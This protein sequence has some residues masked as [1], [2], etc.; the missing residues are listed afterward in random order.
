MN[1]RYIVE[2]SDDERVQ[3]DA[4]IAAPK[5]GPQMRTRAQL[6]LACGRGVPDAT[7]AEALSCGTSTIYRTKKRFVEEGLEAALH[8]LPREG[9]KRK[10][11][12]LEEAK[13]VALACS[14]PPVGR[15]RWTLEL[16]ADEI[17]RLTD[18]E[19]ISKETIRRRLGEN[20]LKPWRRKMW[21]IAELDAEYV[22]RMEDV[23]D[24]YAETPDQKRPVVSFDETPIQLIG[25]TRTPVPAKPGQPARIDYEYRRNGTAN[26]FI[27]VDAHRSWRHVKVT[28]Q[29]TNL[30]FA[31]CMRD[32][33]DIHYPN[34][35]RIRVVLDN[36]STHKA[37]NLYEAFAPE[38]ARR[39]LRR[40]E[41]H[42]T[43][44]HASWLNMVEIEISVLAA[45]CLDRRIPDRKTLEHEIRSWQKRRDAS[46]ARIKWM[47]S[48]DAART[49]L[50]KRYPQPAETIRRAA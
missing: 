28:D 42:F 37:K 19:T 36:L 46:G 40:L 12:A 29:R 2:L 44:K 14:Q 45:Q 15:G 22:T 31:E 6:L 1:V 7:V 35:D 30:D 21:C 24:L 4:L 9:G 23:L 41:F 27:F 48:V 20:D 34:A 8:E 38:E 3:L 47:F 13:L 39:I 11:A 32:L 17:V 43:P 33:A 50:G 26:L 5:I 25:E 16:L 10:L 18:H 49:K